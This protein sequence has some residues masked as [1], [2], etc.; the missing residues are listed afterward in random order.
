MHFKPMGLQFKVIAILISVWFCPN[1]EA[2]QWVTAQFDSLPTHSFPAGW[3]GNKALHFCRDVDTNFGTTN[4]NQGC[5]LIYGDKLLKT[6]YE[7]LTD[8]QN[9]LRWTSL[10]RRKI[11]LG[12][13][14]ASVTPI[15]GTKYLCRVRRSARTY[16]GF[17]Q[18]TKCHYRYRD[19]TYQSHRYQVLVQMW[20]ATLEI[21]ATLRPSGH[22][23]T[24]D[25]YVCRIKHRG[26]YYPGTT[27][28]GWRQCHIL[29]QSGSRAESELY[30]LQLHLPHR[31]HKLRSHRLPKN[32]INAGGSS[33]YY[34][35]RAPLLKHVYLGRIKDG[36]SSCTVRI[37]EGHLSLKDYEVQVRSK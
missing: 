31:W 35:C 23:E 5:Q 34:A 8:S 32:A 33:D 2:L 37:G 4:G 18:D 20:V 10:N 30:E 15:L 21:P 25:V 16:L 22:D 7:I 14:D 12:A 27:G 11:P 29:D 17:I 19:R 28:I 24:G 1:I 3:Q 36:E 13:F 6:G 26:I 9:N